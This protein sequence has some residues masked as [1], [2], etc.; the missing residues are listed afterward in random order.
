MFTAQTAVECSTKK[1]KVKTSDFLELLLSR[2]SIEQLRKALPEFDE[3]QISNFIKE[4]IDCIKNKE[5]SNDESMII[6][7]DGASKGN[8]GDAGIGYLIEGK[9]GTILAKECRYIGKTTNNVAEYTAL[10]EALEESLKLGAK[11]VEVFSDSE[12]L[13]RQINGVY[14]VKQ[15]HLRQLFKKIN[16]LI[17][18]FK[19]FRITHIPREKNKEADRLA[20]LGAN[21]AY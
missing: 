12:L 6:H 7:I 17:S 18:Q 20:N 1:R 4:A 9:D 16:S 13:V 21:R 15:E 3:Q 11:T 10:L 2:S 19:S 14:K 8:P 5:D